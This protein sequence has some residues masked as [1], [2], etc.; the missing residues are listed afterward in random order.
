[1]GVNNLPAEETEFYRVNQ[2]FNTKL[3]AS[4]SFFKNI[5]FNKHT[6]Q[7]TLTKFLQKISKRKNFEVLQ[8]LQMTVLITL[9]NSQLFLFKQDIIIY[10]KKQHIYI[11]GIPSRQLYKVLKPGDIV[12]LP[13][14]NTFFFFFKYTRFL[15][16]FFFK[17]FKMKTDKFLLM[18]AKANPQ[19]SSKMPS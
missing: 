9:L 5:F 12:Q 1:M 2:E 10:L 11:N 6:R 3:Y 13:I 7:H 16:D 4:R 14:I 15:F 8:N 18:Y 19:L 17:K